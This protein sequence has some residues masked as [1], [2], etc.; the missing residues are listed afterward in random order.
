M[1]YFYANLPKV[2]N[3]VGEKIQKNVELL[4]A[5]RNWNAL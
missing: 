5:V 1:A 3:N 4:M 2:V